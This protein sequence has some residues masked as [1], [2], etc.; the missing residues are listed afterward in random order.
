M[1][2]VKFNS[3][4]YSPST[5]GSFGGPSPVVAAFGV[6]QEASGS[7]ATLTSWFQTPTACGAATSSADRSM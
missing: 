7:M 2:I 3:F 5:G 1:A 4:A 6:K